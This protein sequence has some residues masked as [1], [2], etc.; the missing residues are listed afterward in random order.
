MSASRLAIRR[1]RDDDVHELVPVREVD[2]QEQV[3]V[4]AR[5]ELEDAGLSAGDDRSPVG[6]ARDALH[7]GI[8][9]ASK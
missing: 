5:H 1:A 2:A 9:R 4:A 3:V 8:A 7:P 6:L